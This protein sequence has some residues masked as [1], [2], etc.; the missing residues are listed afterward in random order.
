MAILWI[1]ALGFRWIPEWLEAYL[2]VKLEISASVRIRRPGWNSLLLLLRP[3]QSPYRTR[4]REP[5]SPDVCPLPIPN[6]R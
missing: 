2:G 6:S 3:Q 5:F 1:K 4:F